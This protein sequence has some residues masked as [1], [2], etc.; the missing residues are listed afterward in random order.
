MARSEAYSVIDM[1]RAA[2]LL[3]P[4]LARKWIV[5]GQSQGG[6]AAMFTAWMATSY[7]P[8][9]DETMGDSLPD[10]TPFVRRLLAD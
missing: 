3:E 2:R 6:Q 8:E 5:I 1:V 4:D 9:L 7:A 10:T